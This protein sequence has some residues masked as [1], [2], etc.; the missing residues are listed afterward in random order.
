MDNSIALPLPA[1]RHGTCDQ[2]LALLDEVQEMFSYG[3][4]AAAVNRLVAGLHHLKRKLDLPEWTLFRQAWMHHPITQMVHQD[5]FTSWSYRKSRGYP[6]DARLLDFIYGTSDVAEEI[7]AASTLGRDIYH[8]TSHAAA[9]VAVRERRDILARLVDQT[10][11]ER[12]QA[13]SVLSIASGH[14]REAEKS[15]AFAA[16]RVNRWVALDQ[17]AESLAHIRKQFAGTAINPFQGSVRGLLADHYK[18]GTFNLVYAAGLYDYLAPRVAMRLTE[19]AFAMLKPGG[20]LLFA[21]FA[22]GIPDDG[23]M[24]TFMDWHLLFRGENEMEEICSKL[25]ACDIA[26]RQI[27]RGR[28]GNVVYAKVT[29]K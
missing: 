27:F 6:G 16:G 12:A 18:L 10:A 2:G 22:S 9:P 4:V 14:L 17:D 29:K 28:N 7:A 23:Y 24:E 3:S 21:N 11:A 26:S 15:G 13:I 25:P 5:P 20:V 1:D 8:V 19:L